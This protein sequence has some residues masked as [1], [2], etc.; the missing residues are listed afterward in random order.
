MI[1]SRPSLDGRAPLHAINFGL[2]IRLRWAAMLGQALTILVVD[3]WLAIPLPLPE[4]FGIVAI[5]LA[6]N[7][8]CLVWLRQRRPASPRALGALMTLDTVLLTALLYLTGG[9]FNPFSFLY[10]VQIALAALSL[11]ARGTWA[12]VVLALGCS[13]FLFL[14]HRDLTFPAT[15]HADHMRV[16]LQGMWVAFGVAA[17]FIVYFLMRLTRALSTLDAQLFAARDLAARKEKLASL[18]TLAAGTAHELATPLSTIATAAR[19]LE[20]ALER[21]GAA[22]AAS[23]DLQL[24]REEV[25]RCRGILDRMALQAGEPVAENLAG[26]EMRS[27]IDEAL[28]ELPPEAAIRVDLDETLGGTKLLV[29]PKALSQILRTLIKNG[30]EA[31]APGQPIV[32]RGQILERHVHI[33]VSDQ[34]SG[35]TAEVLHRAGEPFFTTKA[36]GA[37]MGLGLFVARATVEQLGGQLSLRS[38]LHRGTS[39]TIVLPLHRAPVEGN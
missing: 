7:L 32:V 10:L 35:M 22:D 9:P 38:E 19:E 34:G 17:A 13:G 11:P 14:D 15:S 39:A 16:H 28:C 25:R 5:E 18:A 29:P 3:R 4:L 31:S 20:L 37:G 33:D 1:P 8:G 36:P 6:S 2:F 24:I 30:Q 26:V 23:D 21:S 12:L 27:I